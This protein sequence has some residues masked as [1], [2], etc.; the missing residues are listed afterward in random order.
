MTQG[1]VGTGLHSGQKNLAEALA[2]PHPVEGCHGLPE[3]VDGPTIVALGLVGLAKVEVRQRLQDAIPV[4]HSERA[5]ALSGG[6]GLVIRAH[7]GEIA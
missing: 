5:G 1:E 4:G 3:A 6:D 7:H 2:A